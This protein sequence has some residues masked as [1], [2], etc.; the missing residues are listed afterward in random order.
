[1]SIHPLWLALV[2]LVPAGATWWTGRRVLRRIDDPALPDLLMRRRGRMNV[3]WAL[4]LVAI[5]GLD[6]GQA[7][8]AVPLMIGAMMAASFP[9][10]RVLLDERWGLGAYLWHST[11]RLAGGLAFWMALVLAPSLVMGTRDPRAALLLAALLAVVLVLWLFNARRIWLWTHAATPLGPSPALDERFATVTARATAARPLVYRFGQ[12]GERRAAAFALPSARHAG[13]VIFSDALLELLTPEET[14]AVFAHE[15][16]HLEHYTPRRMRRMRVATVVLVVALLALSILA[17][18]TAPGA[19]LAYT[20]SCSLVVILALGARGRRSRGHETASDLR[21]AELC[22]D[23]EAL[24][25]ALTKLHAALRLPRRWSAEFERTATHP[26]L[27]HRIAALRGESTTPAASAAV[28]AQKAKR[29]RARWLAVPAAVVALVA[30]VPPLVRSL[31]DTGADA[32]SI[33]WRDAPARVVSSAALPAMARDLVVAPG[34]AR[35]VVRVFPAY[36]ARSEGDEGAGDDGALHF[37][38]GALGDT[39]VVRHEWTPPSGAAGDAAAG[40]AAVTPLG[41][42]AALAARVHGD[43]R[44]TLPLALLGVSPWQ[45]E[46]SILGDRGAPRRIADLRGIARCVARSDVAGDARAVAACTV[47]D[48]R[49]AS[50]LVMVDRAGRVETLAS[51]AQPVTALALA[52]DGRV[53]LVAASGR[54]VVLLDPAT[55]AGSRLALPAEVLTATGVEW[56]AGGEVVVAGFGRSGSQVVRI[57]LP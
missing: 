22:G 8:W 51:F 35:Y 20:L 37:F 49:G 50:R 2:A 36:A 7:T 34:G 12:P 40:Y 26:S 29:G 23:A 39:T 30:I 41:G 14:A 1:M 16:A 11:R 55:H 38:L 6:A 24:V 27:V 19:H 56:T 33:A 28:A 47:M 25:R 44:T 42:G 31:L 57:G 18:R 43:Y 46:L 45:T 52:S 21:G 9:A 4:A 5:V 32:P 48:A 53:A 15:V 10:Q 13:A 54:D 17:R 3:L